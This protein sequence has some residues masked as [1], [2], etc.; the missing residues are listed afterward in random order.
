MVGFVPRGIGTGDED[1]N[2]LRL[3]GMIKEQERGFGFALEIPRM[4]TAVLLLFCILAQQL[5][6][7]QSGTTPR[8]EFGHDVPWGSVR[9]NQERVLES[10]ISGQILQTEVHAAP[11][12]NHNALN[13]FDARS[14][15]RVES[16]SYTDVSTLRGEVCQ[17]QRWDEITFRQEI[18]PAD[19]HA[20]AH[21]G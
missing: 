16:V 9:F 17:R 12:G 10:G 19:G 3:R 14:T 4:A 18:C 2:G 15:R 11:G 1:I 8:N 21:R 13:F 5:H 20:S 7:A 6:L